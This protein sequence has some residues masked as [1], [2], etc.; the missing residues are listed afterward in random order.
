MSNIEGRNWI[1]IR[2]NEMCILS[3]WKPGKRNSLNLWR[4]EPRQNR[5]TRTLFM[6]SLKLAVFFWAKHPHLYISYLT[7]KGRKYTEFL[8]PVLRSWCT[9][10]RCLWENKL[11]GSQI[12][13]FPDDFKYKSKS[14]FKKLN[15]NIKRRWSFK[16]LHTS[17][18]TA[19]SPSLGYT[20]NSN[21][22]PVAQK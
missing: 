12:P 15:E 9:T 17:K 1:S 13:R 16:M 10:Q 7:C 8:F 2:N 4:M 6:T 20:T 22:E 11:K 5:E 19:P 18:W 14:I 3:D 21:K